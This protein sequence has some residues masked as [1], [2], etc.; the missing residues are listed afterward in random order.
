MSGR[1][2]NTNARAVLVALKDGEAME[3]AVQA[4]AHYR[5]T[6]H[7]APVAPEGHPRE[8]RSWLLEINSAELPSICDHISDGDIVAIEPVEDRIR[9]E[10]H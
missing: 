8:W 2:T 6:A 3:R 7:G 5:Y 1:F 10:L 9:S 4:L